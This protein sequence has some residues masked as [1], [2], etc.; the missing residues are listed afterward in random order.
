M[1][2]R[3]IDEALA[4]EQAARATRE[5]SGKYSPSMFGRCWRA[6]YWN[7]K[8]EPQSNAPDARSL[9]VFRAGK[10]F[11]DFAQ[12]FLPPHQVEVEIKTEHFYGFADIVTDDCVYDI[13]S[14]HSKSFWYME[15]AQDI[16]EEKKGNIL[17]VCSY[18]YFLKKPKAELVFIS[19]D[20]LCIKELPLP[21]ARFEPEVKAELK[22]LV[23]IWAEDKLPNMCPRAYGN[24]KKTGKPKE[25]YSYC[26]WRTKCRG[27]EWLK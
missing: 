9:R 12:G 26:N 11:H 25:C 13:K 23:E 8:N 6:Q 5:R 19:K 27:E 4:K 17:Q 22:K 15:K 3:L 14:Q 24:D 1:I 20:D 16:Y 18:A 2:E 7:R 10:L 21:L